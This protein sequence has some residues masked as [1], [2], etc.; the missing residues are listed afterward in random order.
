MNVSLLRKNGELRVK[1]P[2]NSVF[3]KIARKYAGKFSKPFWI[4][5]PQVENDIRDACLDI[6]GAGGSEISKSVALRIEIPEETSMARGPILLSLRTLV[7]ASASRYGE[8]KFGTGVVLREG[9]CLR[10]G[11]LN[12]WKTV[13][14]KDTVFDV[15]R[16]P[17]ELLPRYESYAKGKGWK[18]AIIGE[19]IDRSALEKEREDLLKRI[20]EIELLIEKTTDK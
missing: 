13:V 1:S 10:T 6:Y 2:Y 9:A 19:S 20:S 18:I 14:E 5:P 4:F 8:P 17:K 11:S 3:V 12:H 15:H 7:E 16:V